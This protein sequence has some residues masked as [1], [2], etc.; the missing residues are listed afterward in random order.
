M[1]LTAAANHKGLFTDCDVGGRHR[2]R[3][4]EGEL[5]R[6]AR[7]RGQRQQEAGFDLLLALRGKDGGSESEEG[8]RPL[9]RKA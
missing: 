1:Q 2:V 7:G 9:G 4:R 6:Q 5:A 8:S 3:D